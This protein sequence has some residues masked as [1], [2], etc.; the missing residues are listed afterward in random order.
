M[1]RPPPDESA[2]LDFISDDDRPTLVLAP[3]H[4]AANDTNPAPLH[5]RHRNKAF[6]KFFEACRETESSLETWALS[7]SRTMVRATTN[8]MFAGVFGGRH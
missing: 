2:L 8:V 5:V 3:S 7:V 4:T 6:D 1:S